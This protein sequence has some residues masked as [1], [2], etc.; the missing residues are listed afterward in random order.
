MIQVGSLRTWIQKDG[1]ESKPYFKPVPKFNYKTLRDLFD[2][3]EADLPSKLGADEHYNLF[4]T[5]AHHLEGKRQITS[6]QG[7]DIIPFDLDGIDL[8][9]IDEYPP[10]VAEACG[11]DLSKTAIVYSGNGCHIL[12]QVPMFGMREDEKNYMKERKLGYRQLLERIAKVCKDHDLPFDIDTTA[13][14]AARI[15]RVPFTVNK[16][17]GKDD[18]LCRLIQNNLQVQSFEI[19][20]VQKVKA[21]LSL[22]QGSFPIPD[23]KE[24]LNECDFFKWLKTCPDEVH[25]PHAYA[26]LSITGNFSDRAVGHSLYTS[27]SSPSINAKPYDEFL[28][29][30]LEASGPRTCKGI[31]TVWGK[32]NLC[33]HYQKVTSPILLKSEDHIGTENMG[34]TTMSISGNTMVRHYEDLVKYFKREHHYKNVAEVGHTYIFDGT[35]YKKYHMTQVKKFSQDNFRKPVKESERVE[36]LRATEASDFTPLSWLESKPEGMINLANGILD[37]KSNTLIEHSPE[38]SFTTCLPFDY[39]PA[40][41]CPTWDKFIDDVTLGRQDLKDILHEY[42]GYCAYGGEYEHHKALVL[43]GGGKNGKS[44]FIDVHRAILGNDNISTVPLTSI[45]KDNFALADMQGKLCNISE[46]EPP[47]CFKET[48]VF[49]NLT[50]NNVVRAQEKHKPSFKM[51]SRAK[52]VITYNEV[53]FIGDTTT[54]MRRRLLIVPFDLDLE[55]NPT[56]VNSNIKHDLDKELSGIFN[57]VLEGWKRLKANN[58]FTKSKSVNDA[59]RD[60]MES[61]NSFYLWWDERVKEG[62]DLKVK[63]VDAY[64]DYKSYMDE[65]GERS[66]KGRNRFNQELKNKSYNAKTIRINDKVC[67]GYAGFQLKQGVRNMGF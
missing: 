20:I 57:H 8:D 54:G 26:M 60:V 16:K 45:N 56:K 37:L 4:Y 9:R 3:I 5:V 44:T 43:S 58:G 47:S 24:V 7:Q 66:V 1:T 23:H 32:C 12:V 49:K 51:L 62:N 17:K 33:K 52:I 63:A 59:V 61:S 25:E 22:K 31:D 55:N 42:M 15:L 30:A 38:Y 50:G 65:I 39:D 11:F 53:P 34:F 21:E 48:G 13:W 2:N 40:A 64:Q 27:F 28:E 35:H 10:L 41:V 67:K 14:D 36:F 46:E 19:P 18:K 6:W 29:Q